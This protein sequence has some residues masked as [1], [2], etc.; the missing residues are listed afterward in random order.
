MRTFRGKV[1][2]RTFEHVPNS[3][4]HRMHM[5]RPLLIVSKSS[6]G[7][8]MTV[9]LDNRQQNYDKNSLKALSFLALLL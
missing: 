7:Q 8:R 4:Y 2:S 6:S 9:Y 5:R 3:V 1:S